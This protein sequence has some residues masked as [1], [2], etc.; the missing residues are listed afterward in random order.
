MIISCLDFEEERRRTAK[1]F[2]TRVRCPV[3]VHSLETLDLWPGSS[4]PAV[5]ST[6]STWPADEAQR[7]RSNQTKPNETEAIPLTPFFGFWL[8]VAW[9]VGYGDGLLWNQPIF[10]PIWR[11][12]ATFSQK[13]TIKI[14]KPETEINVCVFFIVCVIFDLIRV[15]KHRSQW[16]VIYIHEH[17]PSN[18][19]AHKS[20]YWGLRNRDQEQNRNITCPFC[21]QRKQ[22]LIQTETL[23]I[24]VEK[25]KAKIT[26]QLW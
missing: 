11:L 7:T 21:G 8:S 18:H 20:A 25:E 23:L 2:C 15:F 13:K 12:S 6:R 22:H 14:E 3:L 16:H 17:H 19:L 26:K 24:L 9:L 4:G 10:I 5:N 1:G